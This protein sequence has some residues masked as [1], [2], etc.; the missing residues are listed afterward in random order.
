M[1]VGPGRIKTESLASHGFVWDKGKILH[2]T[3]NEQPINEERRMKRHV[4]CDA[5]KNNLKKREKGNEKF[6]HTT[7]IK[8]CKR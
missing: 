7:A 1:N 5:H 8:E 4:K 2:M 3:C 6:I